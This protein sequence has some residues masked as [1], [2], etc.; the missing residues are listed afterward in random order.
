MFLKETAPSSGNA[1]LNFSWY[2]GMPAIL[3]A[4]SA[5]VAFGHFNRVEQWAAGLFFH[6][7]GTAIPELAAQQG[8]IQGSWGVTGAELAFVA[9]A[10]RHVVHAGRCQVVAGV[11]AD[12]VA[13]GQAGFV[14]KL[15]AEFDLF[16]GK[17]T[18]FCISAASGKG[19]NTACARSNRALS[20][21][22]T[23]A[24]F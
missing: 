17:R 22:E 3:A 6:I 11:T 14:P 19:L 24:E 5:S 2:S 9:R 7:G 8:G 4:A 12:G 13:F 10:G 20:S 15:L 21:A 16:F 1:A 18:D 23:S